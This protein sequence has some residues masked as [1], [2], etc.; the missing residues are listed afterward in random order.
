MYVFPGYLGE[1]QYLCL[2]KNAKV[3]WKQHC[4]VVSFGCNWSDTLINHYT[5]LRKQLYIFTNGFSSYS[6]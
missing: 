1:V 2:V 6:K 3:I 5:K 4:L